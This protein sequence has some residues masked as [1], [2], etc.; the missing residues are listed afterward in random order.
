M[1]CIKEFSSYYKNG[2]HS[3]IYHYDYGYQAEETQT[4]VE[5]ASI[6]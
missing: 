1:K 4:V 5:G 3:I 6:F 2:E